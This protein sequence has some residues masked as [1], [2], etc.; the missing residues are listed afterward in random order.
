MAVAC[1]C[2][3]VSTA[4]FPRD[5]TQ[6]MLES[7]IKAKSMAIIGGRL[8]PGKPVEFLLDVDPGNDENISLSMRGPFS[9]NALAQLPFPDLLAPT[10]KAELLFHAEITRKWFADAAQLMD[11]SLQ[12]ADKE[13]AETLR[14]DG[15]AEKTAQEIVEILGLQL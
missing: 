15:E 9:Y 4:A 3:E 13:V 8:T 5:V 10:R 7:P 6:G 2:L 1:D 11:G 12:A 14:P